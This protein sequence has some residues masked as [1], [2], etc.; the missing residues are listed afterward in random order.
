M[1]KQIKFILS[2]LITVG[3]MTMSESSFAAKKKV[4]QKKC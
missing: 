3:L 1:V 4:A 2:L